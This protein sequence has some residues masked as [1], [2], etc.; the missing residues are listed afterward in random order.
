MAGR[1]QRGSAAERRSVQLAG[2]E[3][4]VA[5]RLVITAVSLVITALVTARS[6]RLDGGARL[7]VSREGAMR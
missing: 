7:T 3:S 6:E 2:R 1:V 4:S 5:V